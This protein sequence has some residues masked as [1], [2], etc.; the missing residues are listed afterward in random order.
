MIHTR[1]SYIHLLFTTGTTGWALR[2]LPMECECISY[3]SPWVGRGAP[4]YL[5]NA[6]R[7]S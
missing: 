3:V 2:F 7:A 1:T 4:S 6:V 5:P